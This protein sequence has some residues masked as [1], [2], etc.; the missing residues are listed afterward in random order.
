MP[1]TAVLNTLQPR[2]LPYG[3]SL[4]PRPLPYQPNYGAG[5]AS[6]TLPGA[7]PFNYSPQAGGVPQVPNPTATQGQSISGNLSNVGGIEALTNQLN[8]L[9]LQFSNQLNAANLGQAGA[10]N[11]LNQNQ[12][13]W[14]QQQANQQARYQ[15]ELNQAI[16]AGNNEA[17]LAAKQRIDQLNAQA[18]RRQAELYT[19]GLAGLEA[20]SSANTAAEL[21]G[22]IPQGDVNMLAQQAAQRGAAGGFG[23]GSPSSN[24]ALMYALGQT[25]LG[26]N[27]AGQTD[28]SSAV[29]RTPSLPL[30][31]PQ[32]FGAAS[33]TAPTEAAPYASPPY[34]S[35]QP[36]NPASMLT[37]PADFQAAQYGANVL[38][39]APVPWMAQQANMNALMQ[40]LN[41]GQG[42]TA[43]GQTMGQGDV[44]WQQQQAQ[45]DAIINKYRTTATGQTAPTSGTGTYSLSGVT[46]LS[47]GQG[48]ASSVWSPE[49][50]ATDMGDNFIW[51]TDPNAN[52][53]DEFFPTP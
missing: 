7:L 43:P 33:A 26:Q 51:N 17:A 25:A 53:F 42:M 27:R 38:G 40:G 50:T 37:S 36:F 2:P 49:G 24:A 15:D 46:G 31:A 12:A 39:A 21:R 34:A 29:A 47:P 9:G 8:Q 44:P 6:P 18:I 19:P 35:A 5:V 30:Y 28:L 13:Q 4:G 1:A 41:R 48:V 3:G 45:I 23:P 32:F 14:N 16:A 11:T 22:E 10:I 52:P 20:Q